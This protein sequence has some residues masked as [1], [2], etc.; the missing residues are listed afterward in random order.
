MVDAF[1]LLLAGQAMLEPFPF[2]KLGGVVKSATI[3]HKT[4]RTYKGSVATWNVIKLLE[5]NVYCILTVTGSISICEIPANTRSS[6]TCMG[7]N[8]AKALVASGTRAWVSSQT[9]S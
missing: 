6:T 5:L 7:I 4:S 1:F 9:A 8:L 3:S 2:P